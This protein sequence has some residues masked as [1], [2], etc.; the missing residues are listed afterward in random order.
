MVSTWSLSLEHKLG[1][2]LTCSLVFLET[3]PLVQKLVH[4][5]GVLA[6]SLA[7]V[8]ELFDVW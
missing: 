8:L 7:L 1:L 4:F 2:G 6:L 5:V 3:F